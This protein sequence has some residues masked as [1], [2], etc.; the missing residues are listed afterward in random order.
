MPLEKD[1]KAAVLK[2]TMIIQPPSLYSSVSVITSV[3]FI[4]IRYF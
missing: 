2:K 3:S 4:R 1:D